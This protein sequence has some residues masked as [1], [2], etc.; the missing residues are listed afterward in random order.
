MIFPKVKEEQR[1]TF[2]TPPTHRDKEGDPTIWRSYRLVS[3]I[4]ADNKLIRTAP[5]SRSSFIRLD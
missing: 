5:A 4:N 2:K 3:V 1:E